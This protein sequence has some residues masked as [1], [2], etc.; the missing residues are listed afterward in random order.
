M[1]GFFNIGFQRQVRADL[2]A[3]GHLQGLDHKRILR[4]HHGHVQH[5]VD[6]FERKHMLAMLKLWQ[7]AW[8]LDRLGWKVHPQGEGNVQLLRQGVHQVQLGHQAQ[9]HQH[10]AQQATHF[11][12]RLQRPLQITRRQLAGLHQHSAQQRSHLGNARISGGYRLV[13]GAGRHA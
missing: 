2:Q 4:R 5:A 8:H 3:R 12:L 1:Q 11:L 9:L 10:L 7:Q 13:D 6:Q